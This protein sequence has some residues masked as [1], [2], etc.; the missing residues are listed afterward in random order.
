MVAPSST[1][2]Y[3][4]FV[5]LARSSAESIGDSIL[6]TVRKAAKLAVYDEMMMRVK[7]HQMPPTIRVDRAFGMSS[8]PEV[9]G[10]G[11]NEYYA[12]K[13]VCLITI[14]IFSSLCKKNTTRLYQLNLLSELR[15][16]FLFFLARVHLQLVS[17]VYHSRDLWTP[18]DFK[19]FKQAKLS[20]SESFN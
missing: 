7:N 16:F 15:V 2:P 3:K 6:S 11:R 10:S 14:L 1:S 8:E 20:R 18:D 9:R 17:T 12:S 19:H 13:H 5:C 4:I